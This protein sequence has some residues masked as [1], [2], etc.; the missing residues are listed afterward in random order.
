[1]CQFF[2]EQ[3]CGILAHFSPPL[4]TDRGLPW[5]TSMTLLWATAVSV[6]MHELVEENAKWHSLQLGAFLALHFQFHSPI[7][8]V[9]GQRFPWAP[10]LLFGQTNFCAFVES[11]VVTFFVQQS[12]NFQ[13]FWEETAMRVVKSRYHRFFTWSIFL[14]SVICEIVFNIICSKLPQFS[15]KYTFNENL[16]EGK[17]SVN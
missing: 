6:V 4:F 7:C 5:F 13:L 17:C 2:V 9:K 15:L 14:S 12:H 1:M 8:D 11:Q 3:S 10:A 16:R